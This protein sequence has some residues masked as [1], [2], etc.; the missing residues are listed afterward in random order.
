MSTSKFL[1]MLSC[2]LIAFS[3]SANAQKVSLTLR[4]VTV[5]Q[6]ILALQNQGYSISV[7]TDDVDLKKVISV[8]ARNQDLSAVAAQ[9]FEGQEVSFSVDGK[10][11]VVTKMATEASQRQEIDRRVN[12]TGR[13]VESDGGPLIGVTVLVKGESRGTTTNASGHYTISVLPENILEFHF[14][15]FNPVEIK[16]GDKTVIN[17]TLLENRTML[18]D[19]VVVGYGTQ[20]RKTLTSAI[21]K[22]DGDK[23]MDAPVSTVGDAL[24]GK[25][26]GMHIVSNNNLPGQAPSFLIRGGSSINR[27]NA[28]LCLVDGV[29]RSF[30]DLN[31]N[32]I[33][34]FEVFKDAASSAIYGSRASNGVILVTTKK[35]NAF[36]APQIV[37]DSQF[38][39]VSPARSWALANAQDY[40]TIVRPAALQG[41]NSLLVLNGANG[42]GIGNTTSTAIYSTRYLEQG[43]TIPEGYQTMP[44]PIDAT[45][46]ILFKSTDWQRQWYGPALYHKQYIGLNGG[47]NTIKYAASV[48]YLEDK[49]MVAMSGYKNF[50]MHGNTSFKVTQKLTASTTFD[51]SR[52]LKNPL[53]GDY[54]A[55]LGRGLMMSPTHIGKYP[56]GTFATGGT[57]KNQQTAEFYSKFYDRE[58]SLQRFMGR[59]QLKWNIADWLSANAQYS[60]LGDNYRGSYYAYGEREN[61]PNF[62]SMTRS[63]TET[64]TETF[65]NNFQAYL[66]ADK[67]FG[68]HKVAGTIGY[69]YSRWKYYYLTA[70]N[71][72]ALDDKIPYLQSGSDNTAG[73]MSMRNEEYATGMISYFARASYNFAD[74]YILA[75][76]IR[77]DGSSLFVGKNKWGYF[78]SMS[79][80]WLVSEEPFFEH[81]RNTVNHLKMRISYGQTGN[82]NISRTA[83]L[84][85][86]SIGSYAGHNTLLP[87]TM[88]NA[89]L[90]WETTTQLDF[91]L[92]VGFLRDRIRFVF[93]YYDKVTSDLIYNITLPDTGQFSSVTS[94]V[95]SV[96]FYGLEAE[97]HTVNIQRKNFSWETDFTYSFN[98][99][100]VLSLPEEYRYEIVDMDGNPTGKYGYRIGGYKTANGYRFGGTA[101]GEP[102]GRIWGYKVSGVLQTEEEAAAAYFDTMS[103]G[104][105]RSDG[106]S[107]TGRKDAGDFEWVNRYG[108]AKTA[109]GREQID[110]TDMFLLGYVTPHSFGGLNNTIR[111]NKLT[112]NVYF[113]YVIGHSI[114]NYMKSRML[115]NTL[116]YC[117]SNV[118]VKL[119]AQCW[120]KPDD[121][122]T[123]ARFFPNDADYGNRNFSRASDFNVE[124]ANYLCLRDLSVYY[125]LPEKWSAKL[126]MKK[127]TVGVTGNTL[128]YFTKVSGAIGPE[129][130]IAANAGGT[131][132][133]TSVQMGASNSNIIPPSRKMMFNIKL[134]F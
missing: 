92:D 113:D 77:A 6:A 107:I 36:K 130:G 8:D 80:A 134:I 97:I 109:D 112:L 3:I 51:Y 85:A 4:N 111:W 12:V 34:S 7:K 61:T 33:E 30:S 21:A 5:Q 62:I 27:S 82:N 79:A 9:I 84:G 114:Y 116:G 47:N 48:G 2:A 75:G 55:A 66:S 17:C 99:N 16:V 69:D 11:L 86:Y 83:P 29:V 68:R 14:I 1:G 78:P 91:G 124:K 70:T 52:N 119:V 56:D 44:D 53:T 76:T 105:L 24:K 32:D 40:L 104:Y 120:R 102:L 28:P 122:A 127:I 90:K 46:S 35:G 125:D 88:Q 10:V 96:R 132:L 129:T 49:G 108:T 22:V 37:F 18:E 118:D 38:G 67:S 128:F 72:G 59:I 133:Y 26:T 63:T 115:Q 20:S 110:A 60:V 65:R 74:R 121:G 31:P 42:A 87:S 117:N 23:L 95:G 73:T 101:V 131:D 98:K 71:S 19:I 81:A 100:V 123:V 103:H 94:N 93:D 89:A 126:K 43:K 106:Q 25:V 54:F 13:V 41:P 50:T 15:G 39:I 58:N 45:K 57:N 64:R